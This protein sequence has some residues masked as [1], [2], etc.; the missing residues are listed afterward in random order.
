M[1]ESTT[2]NEN[3][4]ADDALTVTVN[5]AAFTITGFG[6]HLQKLIGIKLQRNDANNGEGAM[7]E[8]GLGNGFLRIN[9][10]NEIQI[11]TTVGGGSDTWVSLNDG[12]G[13]VTLGSGADNFLLFEMLETVPG[14]ATSYDVVGAF[15][16]GSNYHQLNNLVFTP[17]ASIT[18]DNLGF[19]RSVNQRGQITRFS[20]IDSSGYLFHSKL[21]DLLRHNQED[22][23]DFGYA[24]LIVGSDKKRLDLVAELALPAGSQIDGQQIAKFQ[25]YEVKKNFDTPVSS[26]TLPNDPDWTTFDAIFIEMEVDVGAALDEIRS[27]YMS[28]ATFTRSDIANHMVRMAGDRD[29]LFDPT[30]R[31]LSVQGGFAEI[32]QCALIKGSQ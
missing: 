18:G 23:W 31:V 7:I 11:N 14:V 32:T 5:L 15:F 8:T 6:A 2:I 12:S 26:V 28:L 17:D 10:S 9:T 21:E 24:R 4:Y 29:L 1:A 16:D 25:R 13:N 22:N 30:T 19:S 20:A 27:R 3:R